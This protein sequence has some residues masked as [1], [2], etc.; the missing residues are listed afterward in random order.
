MK[1]GVRVKVGAGSNVGEDVGAKV[2]VKVGTGARVDV[3]AKAG[4][5]TASGR[6]LGGGDALQ[7]TNR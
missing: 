4:T 7:L 5:A 2:G 6:V 1:V 3:E